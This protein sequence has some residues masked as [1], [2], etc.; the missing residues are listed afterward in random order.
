VYLVQQDKVLIVEDEGLIANDIA[1]QLRGSGYEVSAIAASGEEALSVIEHSLPDLVLMDIR[2]K[3]KLDGI[4]AALQIRSEY[5]LPVIFLT[6]HAD[7]DT[8]AR[9]KYAEPYGY[10]IKPFRQLTL[11]SAIE[12]A[13]FKSRCERTL[14]EREAWLTTVLQSSGD[15]TIVTN[16]DGEVQ[17]LNAAAEHLLRCRMA[18]IAGLRMSFAAPLADGAT[19]QPMEWPEGV[20]QKSTTLPEG[21][22][23]RRRHAEA[24]AV[25]GE[26]SPSV[27]RGSVVGAVIT[28][29]DVSQ[30]NL[31]E[32]EARHQ[33]K[34]QAIERMAGKISHDFN[35]LLTVI[36]GH[37]SLLEISASDP[38]ERIHVQA[39]IAAAETATELAKQ[40]LALSGKVVLAMEILHVNDRV[41]RVIRMLNPALG[42]PISIDTD[43]APDTGKIRMNGAQL[44]QVLLNLILNARDAMPKGGF[45]TIS[46]S[47]LDR[48]IH[49]PGG[50]IIESMVSIMVNDNGEGIAPEVR[51]HIF[52]PFFTTKE[53]AKGSGLGLSIVYGI[54]KD[55]GGEIIVRSTVGAGAN[56]NILLPRVPDETQLFLQDTFVAL[57]AESVRPTVLLAD[58]EPA[59]RELLQCYLEQCGFRVLVAPDGIEALELAQNHKGRIDLLLSDVLM[60]QMDGVTLAQM[61]TLV[62]PDMNILL[63]SAYTGASFKVMRDNFLRASF[64]QKPFGLPELLERVL[65]LTAP[66]P[67]LDAAPGSATLGNMQ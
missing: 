11:C 17:F 6:S 51:D 39:M 52:E 7:S 27:F 4:D 37:G 62:R 34:M 2:L 32:A 20:A 54:I 56:F 18:D 50:D 40:L 42:A 60:P 66:P 29:R 23:L 48:V 43:F 55:A 46:T 16:L 8:V 57:P 38:Q 59:L 3:G 9:A 21:T 36:L 1:T 44:D 24:I 47:N 63:M 5:G 30:R 41:K 26:I 28:M 64:L 33:N 15:P 13:L 45:I 31:N 53:H 22:I 61:L 58:D 67:M 65:E 14:V 25:A 19:G 49:A 12:I 10:L 35:N